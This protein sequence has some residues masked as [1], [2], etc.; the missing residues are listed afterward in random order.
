MAD[1]KEMAQRWYSEVMS[2]GKTEVIDEL[3]APD[4]FDHD[5]LPGTTAD[6]A[7]LK[8]FVAQIRAAF[9]DMQVTPDDMIAEGDQLAVRSTMRGTHQGDFMGI[10]ATGKRAS[11]TEMHIGRGV[12]GRL[13]E[14]WAVVDQLGMLVQ[15]GVVPAPG[16]TPVTV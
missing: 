8:D 14:H 16:R 15:L 1:Y 4:F 7:G 6:L 12:D 9:P 11:W 2:G 3:C 5:P 13:T 10:P